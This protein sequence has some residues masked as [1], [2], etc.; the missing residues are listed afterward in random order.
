MINR[1]IVLPYHTVIIWLQLATVFTTQIIESLNYQ[2]NTIN[3]HNII[4]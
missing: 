2:I 4:P 1:M 3:K